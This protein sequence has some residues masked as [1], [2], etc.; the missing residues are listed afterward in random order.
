[1]T[2][3][4]SKDNQED[5]LLS[6]RHSQKASEINSLQTALFSTI[7]ITVASLIIGILLN[8]KDLSDVLYQIRMYPKTFTLLVWLVYI[9]IITPVSYITVEL[10][11]RK[12][13][14]LQIEHKLTKKILPNEGHENFVSKKN[15]SCRKLFFTWY[16]HPELF[17]SGLYNK[18]Y[19]KLFFITVIIGV[20]PFW[21]LIRFLWICQCW[22]MYLL[23]LLFLFGYFILVRFF[24]PGECKITI[25]QSLI[26]D[27]EKICQ[28]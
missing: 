11:S 12:I 9:L 24:F 28:K 3:E 4:E 10:I 2:N 23:P 18:F 17:K 13:H 27:L 6:Q 22:F 20:I 16:Y 15:A 5:D 1:M 21:L 25:T 26:N 7:T 14:K 8:I 19:D